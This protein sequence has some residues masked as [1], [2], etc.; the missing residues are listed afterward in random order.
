LTLVDA[1]LMPMQFFK[2]PIGYPMAS[3]RTIKHLLSSIA[4]RHKKMAPMV[5][6]TLP[7]V[8]DV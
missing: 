5:I 4:R 3:N 7:L 1:D 2:L 8:N 6:D